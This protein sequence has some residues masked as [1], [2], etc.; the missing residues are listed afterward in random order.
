MFC[1]SHTSAGCNMERLHGR[2]QCRRERFPDLLQAVCWRRGSGGMMEDATCSELGLLPT[3]E[4]Y[5]LRQQIYETDEEQREGL[6]AKRACRLASPCTF[7]ARPGGGHNL[8]RA[9][10]LAYFSACLVDGDLEKAVSRRC[11][12]SNCTKELLESL[13][14]TVEIGFFFRL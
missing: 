5:F 8:R 4:F 7:P 9:H 6:L 10:T 11:F 2:A 1:H 12:C 13:C 3:A 14:N